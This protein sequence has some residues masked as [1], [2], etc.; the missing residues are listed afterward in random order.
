VIV[1]DTSV[2]V[3]HM[4]RGD[5]RH[6]EVAAWMRGAREE[7]VTSPLAVAE[8]DHLAR[9]AGGRAAA[10]ALHTNIERGSYLVEWWDS[11]MSETIRVA[12]DQGALDLG[13]TD[14][15]LIVL[16]ARLETVR[17]ATLDERHFRAARPLTGEPAFRLLPADT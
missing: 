14:A 11:A 10:D 9:R 16:A 6:D 13:L 1:L 2:V 12:R 15:S 4:D 7:L 17:V 5:R 8:M 3:A